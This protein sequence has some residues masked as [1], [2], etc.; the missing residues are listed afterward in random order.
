MPAIP[1][2][3]GKL[4]VV[5][6]LYSMGGDLAPLP[7]IAALCKKYGARLMVD[8]AH[9]MGVMGGGRGTAAHFGVT[10]KVDLIMSTFSK[11]FA[12]LGGFIA[13]DDQVDPLHQAPRAGADLQRQHPGC[14]RGRSAGGAQDHA[15]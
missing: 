9:G 12:S 15:G 6:G 3:K 13:G 5:D 4:V 10:D 8:D 7:E 14:Q 1:D 2:E 11:S